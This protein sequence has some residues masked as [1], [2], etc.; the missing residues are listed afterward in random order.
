M[1]KF[2]R[3]I[4]L[5]LL[6][7]GILY[8]INHFYLLNGEARD[9]YSTGDILKTSILVNLFGVVFGVLIESPKL[10]NIRKKVASFNVR[11]IIPIALAVIAFIPGTLYFTFVDNIPVVSFLAA[12]L[13]PLHSRLLLSVLA[14]ILFIRFFTK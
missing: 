12:L 4:V 9:V 11:M 10:S 3:V 13:L 14:G 2:L 1:N 7:T 6:G 8:F 5:V